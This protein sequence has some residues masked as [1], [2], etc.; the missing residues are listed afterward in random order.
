MHILVFW[1]W[2]EFSFLQQI[3]GISF[4]S[5]IWCILCI[6]IVDMAYGDCGLWLC[7]ENGKPFKYFRG[8]CPWHS[9]S[10]LVGP[11][12]I[13]ASFLVAPGRCFPYL[14]VFRF[15][16][17]LPCLL[18]IFSEKRDPTA[19]KRENPPTATL[20]EM[21]RNKPEVLTYSINLIVMY[22]EKTGL[23]HFRRSEIRS[24][25]LIVWCDW[26]TLNISDIHRHNGH[27]LRC[28]KHGITKV[29][30]SPEHKNT[31]H[32]LV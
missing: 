19:V 12:L 20:L 22:H 14:L 10:V 26:I 29:S 15:P 4:I 16:M 9:R 24:P 8:F 17:A 27:Q 2:L 28:M 3:V 23:N 30:Y 18:Y 1:C 6:W 31:K 21:L 7:R 25:I 13:F 5:G 32:K 11:L